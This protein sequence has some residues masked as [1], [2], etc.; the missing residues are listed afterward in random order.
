VAA[1]DL[2]RLPGEDDSDSLSERVVAVLQRRI[3]SGEIPI[4]SWLRHGTIADE[5]GISRTPVREALRILAAQR[6]VTINRNKGAQV[7]GQSTRNISE[8]G[9]VRAELEGFAAALAAKRIDDAQIERM[10]EARRLEDHPVTHYVIE[11]I[12]GTSPAR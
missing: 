12:S 7:N 11:L 10:N 6:I 3:L 1:S 4:G 2:S 8:I 9:E 5:F